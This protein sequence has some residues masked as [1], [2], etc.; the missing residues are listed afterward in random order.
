MKTDVVPLF[1][2][3]L[4]KTNLELD[5]TSIKKFIESSEFY[6]LE[7][8]QAGYRSKNNYILDEPEMYA[9]KEK[10]TEYINSCLHE[11]LKVNKKVSFYLTNSWVMK[12]VTGNFGEL[13]YHNNSLFSG[14]FYLKVN[15]SSGSIVFS[16]NYYHYNLFPPCMEILSDSY[17]IF[18]STRWEIKPKTNDLLLFPSQIEHF[19]N[20][21]ESNEDRYVIAFNIFVRGTLG[22]DETFNCLKLK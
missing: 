2:S 9:L 5:T 7:K 4:F 21:N 8:S 12:H 19:V 3:P 18:N 15:E 14:I 1:S 6:I 13:H 10:I 22:S 17:N 16:K 20:D 11:I